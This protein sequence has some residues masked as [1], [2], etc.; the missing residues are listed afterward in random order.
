MLIDEVIATGEGAHMVR[1]MEAARHRCQRGVKVSEKCP[2]A[3]P[4]SFD[5][6]ANS[7]QADTFQMYHIVSFKLS[8]TSTFEEMGCGVAPLATLGVA[9]ESVGSNWSER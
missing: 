3:S 2:P 5:R 4:K 7:F 1:V 8:G 6:F 9:E